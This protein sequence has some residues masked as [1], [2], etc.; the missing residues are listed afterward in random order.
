MK[1]LYKYAGHSGPKHK[2]IDYTRPLTIFLGLVVIVSIGLYIQLELKPIKNVKH[3]ELLTIE[4]VESQY[5]VEVFMP[6][7]WELQY[8]CARRGANIKFDGIVGPNT[9]GAMDWIRCQQEASRHYPI[10]EDPNVVYDKEF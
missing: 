7:G 6:T 10:F 3:A 4:D 5:N 1:N 9:I 2:Q 8:W